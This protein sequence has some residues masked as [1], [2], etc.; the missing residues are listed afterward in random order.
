[1]D[2][3]EFDTALVSA[4]FAQAALTGWPGLSVVD[5]AR[6]AGLPLGR[7]RAR[8]PGPVAVLMRFGL[9]AD[10]A[11]LA[12]IPAEPRARERVFDL[13]MRRFDV[14]Q[15][16][17]EGMLAL[18]RSLPLNPVLSL[19][20]G[21]ATLR[22]MGWMLDTAGVS[23]AGV[24][25][26]VR[27]NALVGVWLYALR[28][29]QKDESADLAGTMA[30]LDKALDQAERFSS[31]L[32]AEADAAPAGDALDGVIDIPAED[33]AAEEAAMHG[34]LPDVAADAAGRPE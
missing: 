10:D 34:A 4:A 18:L 31:L 27:A 2:D 16:H 3:T 14:L 9:M 33:I 12:E 28:A 7:A 21:A 8:F 15:E 30:A 22:S 23:V 11:A 20:L 13:L 17:R 19:M 26:Q 24:R 25:G 1:M 6:A 32:G 5:A 29:W